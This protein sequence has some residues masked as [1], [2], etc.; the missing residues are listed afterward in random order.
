MS[1]PGRVTSA[2]ELRVRYSETDQMGVVYHAHYLVW[3]EVA[4]TDFIRTFGRSYAELERQG[5]YLAVT[6]ANV[7][8]HASARY[9]DCIRV[10]VWL[11]SVRTRAIT[12]G[13]RIS[14]VSDER[15][16]LLA[17]AAT[18]LVAI[19]T[20]GRSRPLP[21]ELLGRLRAALA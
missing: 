15:E 3:C 19:G 10:L 17:S 18:R 2:T 16:Q 1:D 21:D 9:D 8:Y 12:F 20:D 11:D 5:V 6:E 4:R 14:R 13:Y 7:R